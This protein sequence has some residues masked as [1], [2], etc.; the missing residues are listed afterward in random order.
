MNTFV[1]LADPTRLQI[2]ELISQGE[3][4]VGDIVKQFTL[5]APTISQHLRVLR[6]AKLVHVRAAGQHRLYTVDQAGVQEMEVWLH[7]MSKNWN[8]HL[9]TLENI[10]QQE[11]NKEINPCKTSFLSLCPSNE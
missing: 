4:S 8:S 6:Q 11:K 5:K 7:R 1:A 10:L 2:F 3:K 9:D